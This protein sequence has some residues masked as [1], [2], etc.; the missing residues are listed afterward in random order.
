MPTPGFSPSGKP[1]A[2]RPWYFS[3]RLERPPLC[4]G[5]GRTLYPRNLAVFHDT[6]VCRTCIRDQPDPL[7]RRTDQLRIEPYVDEAR[8]Y[9]GL[10]FWNPVHPTPIAQTGAGTG[11]ELKLGM[12]PEVPYLN[13]KSSARAAARVLGGNTVP[14]RTQAKRKRTTTKTKAKRKP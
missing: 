12:S 2:H 8:C 14:K 1:A 5:C 3:V 6:A 10:W 9:L 4:P 7:A 11:V 13:K